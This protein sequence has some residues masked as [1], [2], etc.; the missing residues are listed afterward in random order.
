MTSLT[1]NNVRCFADPDPA[2]LAPLTLLVGENS[3]GK[4]TFLASVRLAWELAHDPMSADFN[5][6]PFLLG[7]YD[8]IG[9]YRGSRWRADTFSVGFSCPFPKSTTK[10]WGTELTEDG[11]FLA[12]FKRQDSLPVL[13]Q[14]QFTAMP[15]GITLTFEDASTISAC[16][17]MSP[18]G[19]YTLSGPAVEQMPAQYAGEPWYL[20]HVARSYL[21]RES[22]ARLTEAG[23]RPNEQHIRAISFV[24]RRIREEFLQRPYAT[25]PIR[26]KPRRTYDPLSLRPEPE[27]GHVPMILA[28]TLSGKS[29]QRA[30]LQ[31][32]LEK[33]G[34]ASGLY[35]AVKIKK[36]GRKEGTP[37]QVKLNFGGQP[38]FN[39]VDV[40]YGVSQA[41]PI[42]VDIIRAEKGSTLLIQQPEVHLHPRAQAALGSLLIELAVAEKKRFIVETHSDYLIDRVRMDI[43]DSDKL[44]PK[45]VQLLYFDRQDGGNADIHALELD[46][47]GNITNAPAGYRDFFLR[48]EHRFIGV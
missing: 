7:S 39:L 17:L 45:D 42:V 41:L 37:F 48:E 9:N 46:K 2:P 31:K 1:M 15:Y 47:Q 5:K 38:D 40:G 34:K 11:V 6:E 35:S 16:E 27:G 14:W 33:F 8:D 23:E 36:L 21:K 19:C 24:V 30:R 10:R 44:S 3:T 18:N 28:K 20:A 43:R 22:A 25:A 12:T 13:A 32:A 29:R 4:S 26:T